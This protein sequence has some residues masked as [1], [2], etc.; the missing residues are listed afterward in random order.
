MNTVKNLINCF[1]ILKSSV[2]CSNKSIKVTFMEAVDL[3]Q[4]LETKIKYRVLNLK[5]FDKL[6]L[7]KYSSATINLFSGKN[8]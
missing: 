5:A 8:I 2:R 3:F 7:F 4:M 6:Q 1:Q